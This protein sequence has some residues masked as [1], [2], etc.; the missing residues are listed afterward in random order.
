M[1]VADF[2]LAAG[3]LVQVLATVFIAATFFVYRGQL[4]AMRLNLNLVEEQISLL[5]ETNKADRV[6]TVMASLDNH[7]VR[8]ARRMVM[9]NLANKA[10]ADWQDEEIA[11]ASM[12]ASTYNAAGTLIKLDLVP[13]DTVLDTWGESLRDCHEVLSREYLP[14]LESRAG[15]AP[16]WPRLR[17]L[18]EQATERYGLSPLAPPTSNGNQ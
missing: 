5:R 17:E 16:Y 4:E 13:L 18:A 8:E 7:E 6:L 15:R 1:Y 9:S 12:V 11:K 10:F 2:L 3:F 14:H